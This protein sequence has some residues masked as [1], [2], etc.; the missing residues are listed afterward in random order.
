M[1]S[2]SACGHTSPGKYEIL[3][4]RSLYTPALAKYIADDGLIDL[5]TQSSGIAQCCAGSSLQLPSTRVWRMLSTS[6]GEAGLARP[7]MD[8]TALGCAG[9]RFLPQVA[10]ALETID[11]AADLTARPAKTAIAPIVAPDCA[12]AEDWKLCGVA[13]PRHRPVVHGRRSLPWAAGECGG[14]GC[15]AG[16]VR[17]E[18][19]RIRARGMPFTLAEHC[20]VF[21][22]LRTLGFVA[23]LEGVPEGHAT[24]SGEVV[25]S[26][27]VPLAPT[28][29]LVQLGG[30]GR[31]G[32]QQQ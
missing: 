1:D 8:D 11:G 13:A 17:G 9:E 4:V 18:A 32:A 12:E 30:G 14:M 27:T 7:C 6:V 21:K 20:Y 22:A 25:A 2:Q 28:A 24:K 16:E 29:C 31:P 15:A 26:P 19:G 23:Q 10:E 5:F 3:C